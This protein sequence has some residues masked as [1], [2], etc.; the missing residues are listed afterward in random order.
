VESAVRQGMAESPWE[1][2]KGQLVLRQE[3]ERRLVRDEEGLWRKSE[4]RLLN[5]ETRPQLL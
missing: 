3:V 4:A 5:V 1:Q 2:L